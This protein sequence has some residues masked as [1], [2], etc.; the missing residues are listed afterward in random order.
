MKSKE[1]ITTNC[2][3]NQ[4]HKLFESFLER[5]INRVEL[6]KLMFEA[7]KEANALF[8]KSIIDA[9]IAAS[10]KLED[11]TKEAAEQYYNETFGQ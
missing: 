1:K 5:K 2:L 6:N 3:S 8:K 11:I 7:T 4:A 9:Y 10:P